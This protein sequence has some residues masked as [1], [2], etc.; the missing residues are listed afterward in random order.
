MFFVSLREGTRARARGAYNKMHIKMS[1]A[2]GEMG[3]EMYALY[4][5]NYGRPLIFLCS[6][7]A[8]NVP[9]RYLEKIVIPQRVRRGYLKTAASSKAGNSISYGNYIRFSH[10]YSIQLFSY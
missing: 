3:E 10:Q 4:K 5:V 2:G 1:H 6:Q 7:S 9:L 8:C